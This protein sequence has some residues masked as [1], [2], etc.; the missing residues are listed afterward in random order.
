MMKKSP[1]NA[2][3]ISVPPMVPEAGLEPARPYEH[4]HLKPARLPIP[5]PGL[6]VIIIDL[7]KIARIPNYTANRQLSAHYQS[8][9]CQKLSHFSQL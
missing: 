4:W 5:P 6:G 2:P 7:I 1:F 9:S 3:Y 8:S